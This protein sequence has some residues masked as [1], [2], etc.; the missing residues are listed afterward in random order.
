MRTIHHVVSVLLILCALCTVHAHGSTPDNTATFCYDDER[1][2]VMIYILNK[3]F[4][5]HIEELI[6]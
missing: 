2:N 4:M 6:S 5:S 3:T 1:Y